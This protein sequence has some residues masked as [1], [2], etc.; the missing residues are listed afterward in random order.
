[1]GMGVGGCGW[2]WLLLFLSL[3]FALTRPLVSLSI[4]GCVTLLLLLL[5]AGHLERGAAQRGKHGRGDRP[6]RRRGHTALSCHLQHQPPV[7]AG[8][9]LL[10]CGLDGRLEGGA[11]FL[12][13]ELGRE[14]AGRVSAKGQREQG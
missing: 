3:L 13:G 7:Q 5:Q 6:G 14:G 2:V 1:M 8:D 9:D 12:V 10:G 4:S 11:A